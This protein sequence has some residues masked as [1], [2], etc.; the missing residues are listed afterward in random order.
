MGIPHLMH[1]LQTY[2]EKVLFQHNDSTKPPFQ[3]TNI[4]IDGPALAY[5]VYYI[6]LS[7]RS[8]ARN[9]IDAIPSYKE[10]SHAVVAWLDQC[11]TYSIGM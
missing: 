5:H 3:S 2:G 7:R 8:G 4:I 11:E 10:L 1:H 6:C 9:A